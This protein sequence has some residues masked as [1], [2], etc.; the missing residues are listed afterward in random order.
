M[1]GVQ[2]IAKAAPATI[3]P[4]LPARSSSPSTCHSRLS[5]VTKSEETKST[6]MAMISAAEILVSVWLLSLKKEPRPVAVSPRTMKIA[7]KLATKS[8]LGPRTRRQPALSRSS[9]ET[10]LTAER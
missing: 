4:P 9:G 10:P 1:Q 2:A 5:R 8:R 6:P 7:E 3:G